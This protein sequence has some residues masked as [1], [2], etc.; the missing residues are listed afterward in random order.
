[1]SWPTAVFLIMLVW[2]IVTIVG[3]SAWYDVQKKKFEA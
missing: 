3:V 2:A 1:M